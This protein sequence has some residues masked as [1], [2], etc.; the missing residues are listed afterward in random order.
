[1]T[2]EE[3]WDEVGRRKPLHG[4]YTRLS[5]AIEILLE[6]VNRIEEALDRTHHGWLLRENED[7]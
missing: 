2:A 6:K 3:L 7:V 4:N 1:M 5:I